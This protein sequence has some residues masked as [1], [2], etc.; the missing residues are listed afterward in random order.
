MNWDVKSGQYW[1]LATTLWLLLGFALVYFVTAKRTSRLREKLGR[2]GFAVVNVLSVRIRCG[3]LLFL[4]S[5]IV[6]WVRNY[7]MYGRFRG[8]RFA[9]E[10][11]WGFMG[12]W[13]FH[14]I[15]L[16]VAM[17]LFFAL[18]GPVENLILGR[19]NNRTR[20]PMDNA[21]VYFCLAVIVCSVVVLYFR[22]Q[23]P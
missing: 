9:E 1:A 4:T 6:T 22:E 12:W 8:D 16:A 5:L 21:L 18:L 2:L 23:R 14:Y 17:I 19:S 13:F 7:F 3:A 20:L 15:A 11:V 10:P